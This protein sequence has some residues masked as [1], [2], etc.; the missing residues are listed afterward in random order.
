[1]R[2]AM[3]VR[4]IKMD[5]SMDRR[6]AWMEFSIWEVVEI[7]TALVCTNL[8]PMTTIIRRSFQRLRSAVGP[9]SSSLFPSSPSSS[10]SPPWGSDGP[11]D[12]KKGDDNSSD[13][14]NSCPISKNVRIDVEQGYATDCGS[15]ANKSCPINKNVRIDVE[16]GIAN[17]QGSERKGSGRN[18]DI[19]TNGKGT[20][21]STVNV[22]P[23]QTYTSEAQPGVYMQRLY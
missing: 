3:T 17:E 18:F 21:S 16:R 19:G 15:G 14:S 22:T 1:M 9:W 12:E 20:A 10:S 4:F 6:E 11:A 2:L 7:S 5:D 13:A 8:P 23:W